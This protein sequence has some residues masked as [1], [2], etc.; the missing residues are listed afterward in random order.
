M[1]TVL[2]LWVGVL[3]TLY[4]ADKWWWDVPLQVLICVGAIPIHCYGQCISSLWFDYGVQEGNGIILPVVLHCKPYGWVNNIN[5]FWEVLLMV[6][7]MTNVSSIYPSQSLGGEWQHLK[8]FCL[9]VFHVKV[10]HYGADQG[11]IDS[12]LNLLIEFI[13]EGK[14]CII[15]AELLQKNY[16]LD[17]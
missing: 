10:S 5:V 12:S 4:L 16:V 1:H 8:A 15:Q 11:P 3:I 14:V 7:W 2:V 17:W 13:L 6:F 9:E